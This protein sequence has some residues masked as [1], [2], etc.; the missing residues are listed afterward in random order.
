[1]LLDCGCG[2]SYLSF[3]LYQYCQEVL[4]RELNI[5]GIDNNAELIG[6]CNDSAKNLGFT[7]M[8]FHNSDIAAFKTDAKID[9]TY[10]LHACNTATDQ[11]I[12]KGI[13]MGAQYIFSVS[14]CQHT[15][16]E[17]MAGHCLASISRYRPYKERLVDMVGDS[18]RAL[19]LEHLGYGVSIFEFA[20]TAQTPKNI[21]LRAIKGTVKQQDQTQAMAKYK[22][23]VKGFNFAPALENMLN[24]T[25]EMQL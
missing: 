5:I 23:L 17:K 9:I 24:S 1:V 6:K 4:G 22:E 18:M 12:A 21:M 20:T 16:R 14:C 25:L 19:L 2:K 13:N 3:V 10:S 8:Q 11:T 15:N 7:G